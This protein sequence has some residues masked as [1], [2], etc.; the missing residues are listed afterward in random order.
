MIYLTYRDGVG[1]FDGGFGL[2]S[3][4]LNSSPPLPYHLPDLPRRD[5]NPVYYVSARRD[6]PLR[7]RSFSPRST[8]SAAVVFSR[9]LVRVSFCCRRWNRWRG[10]RRCFV[11]LSHGWFEREN[12]SISTKWLQICNSA[13]CLLQLGTR[14][15]TLF[16][17]NCTRICTCRR[18]LSLTPKKHQI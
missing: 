9:A 6:P 16:F 12:L 10:V 13:A 4:A 15:C 3:N 8:I 2:F 7:R 14:I 17:F 18:S 5:H 11:R 1:D